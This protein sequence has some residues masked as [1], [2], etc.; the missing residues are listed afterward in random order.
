[1]S[2]KIEI[3]IYLS[4]CVN[5]ILLEEEEEEEEENSKI[6]YKQPLLLVKLLQS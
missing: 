6:T 3:S 2:A 5:Y 4:K 1:M